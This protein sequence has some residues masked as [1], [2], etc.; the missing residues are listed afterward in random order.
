MKFNSIP[1]L[2][3]FV[4][5]CITFNSISICAQIKAS[6][7][8]GWVLNQEYKTSINIPLEE[9]AYGY[10]VLLADEQVQIPKQER[11]IRF[12]KKITDNIGIQEAAEIADSYDPKYQS[13]KFHEIKVIRN[14]EI[15]D[16]LDINNFQE[17]RR[18]SSSE[19]YIY[20]GRLTAMINLSDIRKGD[21]LDYS[22]TIT[23]FNPIH[24]G[25]FSGVFSLNNYVYINKSNIRLLSK[26]KLNFKLFNSDLKPSISSSNG[27]VEYRWLAENVQNV[28]M[29]F[30]TP[31][32]LIEHQNLFVSNY[33]SWQDVINWGIDI[34]KI[35]DK[36]SPQLKAKIDD[37]KSNSPKDTDR[38]VATLEFVQNEI[39]YLG[40]EDGI[41]SYKPFSPNKV[42]DQRFGDCKDKSLLMVTMLNEMDIKAYPMLVNTLLGKSLPK[43]LPSPKIFDH[44]V[45]KVIDKSG[46]ELY[47]DPTITNQ[48]GRFNNIYFPNYEYGLVISEDSSQL[49][50]LQTF[51]D[52][53]VE[54]F[55]EFDLEAVGK[56]ATLKVKTVYY[57]YEADKMRYYYKNN[58]LSSIQ[59]DY[60]DYY[61]N[62]YEDVEVI[63]PPEMKDD[64]INNKITVYEHYKLEDIW[65]EIL[66]QDN[67][68]GVTFMPTSISEILYIPTEKE[69]SKEYGLYYPASKRHTIKVKLPQQW[70][71]F[72]MD[73]SIASEDFYYEFEGDYN[74]LSKELVLMSYYKNQ[75]SYV[76]PENFERYYNDIKKLENRIAYYIY[77]PKS[78]AASDSN[79]KEKNINSTQLASSVIKNIFLFLILPIIAI[80]LIV[81]LIVLIKRKSKA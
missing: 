35:T 33:D 31:S 50:E 41:G 19:S 64:S 40:L 39:R 34:Y 77:T 22:Y 69:R 18:E 79:I 72:P 36:T 5:F 10:V 12:V 75:S 38:I 42:F 15:I 80:L 46:Y 48:K 61:S 73:Y 52:N 55:D 43:V 14:G 1:L 16:K 24:D 57:E 62:Y 6:K 11:Y 74:R 20:D 66:N 26:D 28:E 29:D 54:V 3:V 30:E 37:I 25:N 53:L 81:L 7:E 23:G 70:S 51:S 44:V 9:V 45:V 59:K 63:K 56:G 58:S 2:K 13:I 78:F 67:N 68:I 76:K 4:Y 27:L 32:W 60:K 49:E 17:I 65:E 71:I 47:Y 8:P 21:I